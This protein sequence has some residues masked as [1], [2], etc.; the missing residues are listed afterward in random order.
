LALSAA[1]VAFSSI[2]APCAVDSS[3]RALTVSTNGSSYPCAWPI[4]VASAT[5][6]GKNLLKMAEQLTPT[7]DAPGVVAASGKA[8]VKQRL[9]L[10]EIFVHKHAHAGG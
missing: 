8:G 1:A 2:V 4:V 10:Y 3:A 5:A 6:T 9:L 7:N